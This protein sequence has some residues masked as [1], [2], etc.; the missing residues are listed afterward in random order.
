MTRVLKD[1]RGRG[2]RS[3]R[4]SGWTVALVV[5]AVGQLVAAP[6]IAALGGGGVFTTADRAGE[7]AIV[8]A[9]YAFSIWVVIEVLSLLWAVW[10][11][12]P[13]GPDP[14]LRVRIAR[15]L[16]VVFAGFTAWLVA[17]ELEPRWATL[18]VFLV[19]LAGLLAATRVALREADRVGAWS[20][21]G[22]AV[23]W[24]T[25]GLYLG[26]SSI[27]IWLNLTTALVA[28]GAP[29]DGVAGLLGQAAVLA[30]ATATAV[31]LLRWTGGLLPYLAAVVWAFAGAVLG[32]RGAGEPVLAVG[33]A[34]GL[35]VVIAAAVGV[36]RRRPLRLAGPRRRRLAAG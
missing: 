35:A 3:G 21:Y 8:P 10:A 33:A 18:A 27:A 19:M 22:R 25:L 20:G 2:R 32:A 7:P 11:A 5:L 17:A 29:L 16:T 6:L 15:P 1:V 28:S 30:G 24:G 36:R 4:W 23:L 34:V 13:G 12:A 26:W 9:G 31:A 14:D